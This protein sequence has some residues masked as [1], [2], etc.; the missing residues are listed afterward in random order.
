[1]NPSPRITQVILL[2]VIVLAVALGSVQGQRLD[3]MENAER[4]YRWVVSA[5]TLSE[6]GDTLELGAEEEG[7]EAMDDELF[8]R[9]VEL[10]EAELP[11]I[12]A[13]DADAPRMKLVRAVRQGM[14]KQV[15]E[16]L[17]APAAKPLRQDFEQYLSEDK[18]VSRGTQ[19][20]VASL[21]D[22]ETQAQG[23]GLPSLFFGFRKV[24]A[25]FLWMQVDQYW[26]AGQI[27]RMVPLMRTTVSL[28]PSFVD[29]YLL[30]AWHLAYNFTAKMRDTPEPLKEFSP[31]YKRRVGPKE[32][33]YFIA[34]DFLKDG[35]RKNPRDYRLYFDLGYAIYENKLEDHVNAVRYLKEA[36][37]Y[38]H[39]QW[40]PRMLY[41]SMWL[42]GQ[43]E[44]A[45]DGWEQY[46]EQFPDSH[47]AKRFLQINKGYLA[48]ARG[49][50]ARACA[51]SARAI[52][53]EL[54]FQAAQA[55]A[56]GDEDKAATLRREAETA[57]ADAIELETLAEEEIEKSM[58]IWV[59][60]IRQSQDS[61]AIS[62]SRRRTALEY[63]NEERYL[64]AVAE[65]EIAR[66]E[67]LDAFD[68]LSDLMIQVKL[69][70]GRPLTVSEKLALERKRE[71][72]PYIKDELPSRRNYIDCDYPLPDERLWY[73]EDEAAVGD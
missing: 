29:A 14:D 37:R 63:A 47:Q 24:A 28:D 22:Q 49:E 9:V 42:N 67:M 5:A 60:M 35:I 34:A 51:K 17:A 45:I 53:E 13:E 66:Y 56:A 57:E 55:D 3:A 18:I 72:Y 64:E 68:E 50:Q 27:H 65:L 23:F 1:M 43:Y 38:K 44:E 16:L 70:G 62:R 32:E 11:E 20:G 6:I 26:H 15:Y 48:E 52:A 30:G 25:N 31:K 46:L 2:G 4:L 36:R 33:W 40:V 69:E 59:A 7:V 61:I 21:Y 39:D 41:R 73:L 12:P 58:R 8:A 54:R 19:F 10:G 71:A